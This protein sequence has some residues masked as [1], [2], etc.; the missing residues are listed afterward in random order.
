MDEESR[1]YLG[2]AAARGT[3]LHEFGHHLENNLGPA[4]FVTLHNFLTART[5]V[6]PG[7]DGMRRD[8][9]YFFE[10]HPGYQIDMPEINVGGL[11]G[12]ETPQ[13][14]WQQIT[15]AITAP[16]HWAKQVAGRAYHATPLRYLGLIGCGLKQQ[17]GRLVGLITGRREPRNWGASG[18]EN[19]F[20]HNA[21]NQQLSYSTAVHN[22]GTGDCTG[23]TEYLS[24]TV[25]FLNRP[26]HVRELVRVDPLRVALFLYLANRS[27]YELVRNEFNIYNPILH[28]DELIHAVR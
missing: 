12:R 21:N 6:T 15:H 14:L 11:A 17:L 13:S 7:G 4:D 24:T 20:V 1:L 28:L 3:I 26:D 8:V 22:F 9:G 25:E 23:S 16:Y 10:H 5:Q 18:V 27:Q 2:W 19:F